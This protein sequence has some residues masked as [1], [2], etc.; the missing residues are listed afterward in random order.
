MILAWRWCVGIP[1]V[2]TPWFPFLRVADT[3]QPAP[4]LFSIIGGHHHHNCCHLHYHP[5]HRTHHHYS[6]W[7]RHNDDTSTWIIQHHRQSS[8]SSLLWSSLSSL[9]IITANR[10]EICHNRHNRRSCKICASCVNFPPK[11]RD[12]SHYLRR[13]SRFTHAK[14]DFALKM[15]KFYTLYKIFGLKIQ[16]CKF[17]DKSHVWSANIFDP[18]IKRKQPS[19][20]NEL[21][22]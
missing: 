21:K 1:A 22:G 16:S 12:F 13:T 5:H 6:H 11:Q 15:L 10:V 19:G 4:G 14:C 8:S 7:Q 20:L 9:I 2:R 3:R 17:F 18:P